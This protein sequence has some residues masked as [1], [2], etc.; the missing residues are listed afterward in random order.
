[1]D[2]GPVRRWKEGDILYAEND[3]A[4]M[5]YV[6]TNDISKVG[7]GGFHGPKEIWVEYIGPRTAALWQ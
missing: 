2:F 5:A 6:E 1:M 3:L 7:T 4:T